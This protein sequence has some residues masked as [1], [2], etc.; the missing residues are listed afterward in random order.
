MIRAIELGTPR[1]AL[2]HWTG[3]A[4]PAAISWSLAA[5]AAGIFWLSGGP[6]YPF[7][8]AVDPQA[9]LSVLSL[10]DARAGAALVAGL[11]VLGVIAGMAMARRTSRTSVRRLLLAWSALI[12]IGLGLVLPDY[13][14]LVLAGYAPVFV[15]GGLLGAIPADVSW[16]DA[17]TW[18]VLVQ[19]ASVTGAFAWAGAGVVYAR[20]SRVA[21]VR[22]G[23]DADGEGWASPARARA[24]GRWATAVAVGIPLVYAATR[25]AWLLGIPLGISEE[26]LRSGQQEGM[27]AAGA[28]LATVATGGAILTTGLVGRWGE[29]IPGWVPL[30]GGRAIPPML[31]T[32]PALVV[33]VLVTS[34]G[35]MFVRM[36]IV[37]GLESF[38]GADA[39]GAIGPELLWPIWGVALGASAVAYHLRRSA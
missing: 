13:R 25:Y 8:T 29:A 4:L 33:A 9:E 37:G 21:C 22:C 35:L 30:L 14:L 27:W 31:A 23:R 18:P 24:W 28:G 11:G 26:L 3:L 20:A 6:G 36:V 38:G 1:P 39:L 19:A 10:L 34:A 12:A 2:L 17:L 7:S 32:L 5:A 15:V 16:F